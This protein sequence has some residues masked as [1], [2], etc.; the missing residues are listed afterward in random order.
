ML[1]SRTIDHMIQETKDYVIKWRRHF[2]QN[3]ELSFH[4][5]KTSQF[6]Y[7]TLESFGNLEL[8]RPTK[9]SVMARLIGSEPGKIIA[10]RADM[11]ALPIQEENKFEYASK[12]PGV[13]HACGHDGHAAILLGVA[14]IFSVLRNYI[15]G[16]VRFLFQHA[17]ELFP[18]GAEEMV[19]AGVM[20]NVDQII[21]L[22]LWSPLEVGKI[23][24]T[25]GPMLAAPDTFSI[26][27]I[28]KGG[29][30]AYPQQTIDSVTIGAQVVNNLQHIVAKN[31]DSLEPLVVSVTRFIADSSHNITPGTVEISGTV[32]SF[33]P[34]LRESVPIIMERIIKGI[35]EAHGASYEFRYLRGYRPVINDD[36][37]TLVIEE[38]VREIFGDDAV[39]LIKPSMG[40]DDF[41]AYLQKAP[42][43]YVFVGAGNTD[44]GIVYPHHHPCFNIDENALQIGVKLLIYSTIKL[45]NK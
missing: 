23:G 43:A 25:Y 31:T 1:D 30:A 14:K 39:Q 42:G 2:H 7:D 17:E 4:E 32:R 29:H 11:D 21:G 28:G 44:K 36:K 24:V 19:E 18:G 16:E 22:H 13:M 27:V 6:I 12:N 45:L 15:N 20:D 8:T 34:G 33:N 10:L 35:T 41:S 5:T 40:G 9:T 38:T 37:V 26:S 3:P